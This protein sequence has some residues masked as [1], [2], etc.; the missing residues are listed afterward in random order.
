[1][2]EL[3]LRPQKGNIAEIS[4]LG[5]SGHMKY[6]LSDESNHCLS[7]SARILTADSVIV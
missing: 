2:A 3:W 6:V 4:E 7:F 5:P 1:M